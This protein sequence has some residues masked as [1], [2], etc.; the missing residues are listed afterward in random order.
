M[1]I[2]NAI[3]AAAG[4]LVTGISS[5]SADLVQSLSNVVADGTIVIGGGGSGWAGLTPFQA[6]PNE[7]STLDWHQVTI[8]NDSS[9]F[10]FRYEMNAGTAYP[11]WQYALYLDTDLSRSTG[12]IGGS[13]QFSIGADVIIEGAGAYAFSPSAGTTWSIEGYLGEAVYSFNGD[14][15]VIEFSVPISALGTDSFNFLL[16]GTGEAAGNHYEDY[17]LDSSNQGIS[18]GYLQY[19]AVPEPGALLLTTVG[20]GGVLVRR[21]HRRV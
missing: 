16:V 14:Y 2:T 10:Y 12:F 18:G 7:G 11:A 17:Y 3:V 5:A 20:L 8:A 1:K 9:Y 21:H 13:G 15:S 19:T 4:V 6:D